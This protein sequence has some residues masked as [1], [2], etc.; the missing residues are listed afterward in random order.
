MAP[1]HREP[2]PLHLAVLGTHPGARHLGRV[3]GSTAEYGRCPV[4]DIVDD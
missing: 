2:A 1:T 3:L 4:G